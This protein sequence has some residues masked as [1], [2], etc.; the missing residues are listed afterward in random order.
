M[1]LLQN[2]FVDSQLTIVLGVEVVTDE[3]FLDLAG[4]TLFASYAS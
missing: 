4:G 2:G 1:G 3:Q